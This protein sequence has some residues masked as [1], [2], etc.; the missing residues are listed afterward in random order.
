MCD[1]FVSYARKDRPIVDQLVDALMAAG[2]EPWID[3]YNIP[4]GTKWFLELP[5]ALEEA[6]CVLGC[7]TENAQI[8]EHV[9]E[10]CGLA[11]EK[12]KLIPVRLQNVRAPFGFSGFQAYDLAPGIE[13]A[14]A[15]G[16]LD[17]LIDDIKER[18]RSK[19]S[20]A[21]HRA[22]FT[23]RETYASNFDERLKLAAAGLLDELKYIDQEFQFESNWFTPLHAEVEVHLGLGLDDRKVVDLL[24]CIESDKA[25]A[26]FLVVG[27]PGAGKSV[28]MRELARHELRRTPT[29]GSLPIY[30][31]LREWLPQERWTKDNPPTIRALEAFL[32]SYLER[33]DNSFLRDFFC[34]YLGRLHVDGRVFWIFDSFDEIPAVLDAGAD[35]EAVVKALSGVL[36]RFI[37]QGSRGVIS[38]RYHRRP[39]LPADIA[40][41]L[42]V[43]PFGEDK[44]NEAL[45][46]VKGFPAPLIA[47]LLSTRPDLLPLARTPFYLGLIAE[48]GAKHRRL[49]NSQI[50]LFEAYVLS[51]LGAEEVRIEHLTDPQSHTMIATAEDIS[52][53]L[54]NSRFGL[55]APLETLRLEFPRIDVGEVVARLTQARIMRK[56]RGPA[57][58][59]S[60]AH[61]RVQ[62]YFVIRH[63]MRTGAPFDHEWIA[64]DTSM[65]D[66][67]VLYVELANDS[68]AAQIARRCWQE[69]AQVPPGTSDYTSRT[70]WRA[71]HCQRFITEAFRARLST[72]KSFRNRMAKRVLSTL[73]AG[74]PERQQ[75]VEHVAT[76]SPPN[77]EP[78]K[79]EP[80]AAQDLITVKLAIETLGLLPEDIIP[81]VLGA[82]LRNGDPWIR[83]S[84][85]NASR[86][87]PKVRPD[88][89]GPIWRSIAVMPQKDFS[90]ECERLSFAFQL[91]SGLS[92]IGKLIKQRADDSRDWRR[93]GRWIAG[94]FR[95][96]HLAP[97]YLWRQLVPSESRRDAKAFITADGKAL[98]DLDRD[99]TCGLDGYRKLLASS[100][101]WYDASIAIFLLLATVIGFRVSEVINDDEFGLSYAFA[102]FCHVVQEWLLF[103]ILP[104]L[105]AASLWIAPYFAGRSYPLVVPGEAVPPALL[106]DRFSGLLRWASWGLPNLLFLLMMYLLHEFAP[107]RYGDYA[108]GFFGILFLIFILSL[109]VSGAVSLFKFLRAWVRAHRLEA[110]EADRL[111][112]FTHADN[113][114]RARIAEN[115]AAL[116]TERA[117][118]KY[119]RW[120]GEQRLEP[121]GDW[122]SGRPPN[123]GDGASSMLARLEYRWRKLET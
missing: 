38:S 53:F 36:A 26:V 40:I 76:D 66:A 110:T 14:S 28:A 35:A 12:N 117:R 47:T 30:V 65:R 123:L 59:C 4:A 6:P 27:D 102:A 1:V 29:T 112:A 104:A 120:L 67:A 20:I 16:E 109:P 5:K 93:F 7:W 52:H 11:I 15:K 119:I 84:A 115:F 94:A 83:E 96:W 99:K 87:L 113:S 50:E 13:H 9:R 57:F 51:R 37:R 43:R 85:V 41:R 88:L 92:E 54:L 100:Y 101:L 56:G 74:A 78:T 32:Q 71:L 121:T 86:F 70:F 18:R 34:E 39:Q 95:C 103:I 82:A 114:T 45:R 23:V 107:K 60:F 42:D 19:V 105:I 90:R 22:G 2:I 98:A 69:I 58:I 8:S 73:E 48:F 55:E 64:L 72:L 21:P 79:T 44:I 75:A 111:A 81:E 10:E 68:E 31:N 89:A 97:V 108:Q 17:R 25:S 80:V 77:V 106:T 33:F 3:R 116:Q 49:P 24:S 62:E 122:P 46:R 63:M 118:E 91:S 61:R